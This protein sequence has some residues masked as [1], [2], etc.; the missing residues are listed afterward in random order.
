MALVIGE[1]IQPPERAEGERVKRSTISG[2]TAELHER[3]QTLFDTAQL[4][5]GVEE[6]VS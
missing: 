1:P 4:L 3:L 6:E 5:A 2:L